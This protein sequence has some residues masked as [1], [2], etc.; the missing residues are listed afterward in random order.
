MSIADGQRGPEEGRKWSPGPATLLLVSSVTVGP[1]HGP[2]SATSD[3]KQLREA[4][5]CEE[6]PQ[7]LL[8][9]SRL[10]H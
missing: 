9:E 7:G 1:R 8:G 6:V 2:S 10:A 4:Y 3:R 5:S